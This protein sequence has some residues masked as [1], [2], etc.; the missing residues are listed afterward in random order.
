MSSFLKS[1][2][3]H[4]IGS[5]LSRLIIYMTGL[6]V[7]SSLGAELY[8]KFS[9]IQSSLITLGTISIVGLSTSSNYFCNKYEDTKLELNVIA[10]IFSLVISLA[11]IVLFFSTLLQYNLDWPLALCVLSIALF[12]VVQGLLIGKKKILA[13]S[14]VNLISSLV[15]FMLTLVGKPKTSEI[16]VWYFEI[17]RYFLF[18]LGFI[19][20]SL[21]LKG[22]LGNWSFK[23]QKE[24]FKEV[25]YFTI[26]LAFSSIMVAPILWVGNYILVQ[27]VNGNESLG[28]YNIGYQLYLILIFVPSVLSPLIFSYF[29][30]NNVSMKDTILVNMVSVLLSILVIDLFSSY[31]FDFL[32]ANFSESKSLTKYFYIT[33][34]IY[35][36]NTVVGQRIISKGRTKF[37]LLFNLVWGLTYI[38]CVFY[39]KNYGAL[40]LAVSLMIAYTVQAVT[41]FIVILH[42][43]S[44]YE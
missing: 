31:V 12:G 6:I 43:R 42:L 1:S 16:A 23:K 34:F 27:Q 8:G 13:L 15:F 21:C 36:L 39:F 17:Y 2:A 25:I 44:E 38:V 22:K 3:I 10:V 7:A 5:G 11:I 18:L 37:S 26:P 4:I 9:F 14:I 19:T 29:S 30:S 20:L 28:I 35:S 24:L 40:A 33:A 32:G 41:Q